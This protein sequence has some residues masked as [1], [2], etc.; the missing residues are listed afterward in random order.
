MFKQPF[1]VSPAPGRATFIGKLV[2]AVVLVVLLFTLLSPFTVIPAGHR[3]VVTTFG[4]VSEDVLDEGIHLII[5]VVNT[6]HKIDVRIQKGE[7][8]GEAASKDL[9]TIHTTVALNYHLKPE[10]VALT[11]QDIGGLRE[12]EERIILP[13]TQEAV[14]AITARYTAEELVAKREEVRNHIKSFLVDRLGRHGILVDEFSVTNFDFSKSFN[15]AI[16]AKTTAEQLKLKA[17]R[18]LQRIRVEAEQKVAQAEAEAK[19]LRLQKQEITPELI[20]LREI[21]AQRLAIEKWNG[22]L[23]SV[24]G[25]TVPFI[26]VGR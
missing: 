4:K 26:N 17:E 7:G 9:Q 14:K 15:E 12:V 1:N 11:F 24:T 8:Q 2:G 13:S 6:V 3:G 10:R 18:D 22:Q 23:P 20:K 16:E 19:A 21:E 5:P 25:G